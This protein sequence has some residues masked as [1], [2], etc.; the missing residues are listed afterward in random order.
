[1]TMMF[2]SPLF[3]LIPASRT[4]LYGN[5]SNLLEVAKAGKVKRVP[6]EVHTSLFGLMST[7]SVPVESHVSLYLDFDRGAWL[8]GFS[9]DEKEVYDL[10]HY[11]ESKLPAWLEIDSL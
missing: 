2:D 5:V 1:M 7:L 9:V 8:F 11:R 4:M 6:I 10:W 3:P